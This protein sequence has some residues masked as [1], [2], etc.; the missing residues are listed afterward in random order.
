[1]CYPFRSMSYMYYV[2]LIYMYI[3]EWIYEHLYQSYSFTVG[4]NISM[5]CNCPG[6]RPRFEPTICR[7]EEDALMLCFSCE[8][9]YFHDRKTYRRNMNI[10]LIN[11]FCLYKICLM[12]VNIYLSTWNLIRFCNLTNSDGALLANF[13]EKEKSVKNLDTRWVLDKLIAPGR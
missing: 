3:K 10:S 2:S 13:P 9:I 6:P 7:Q 5:S 8:L 4:F 12:G 1:M 11:S